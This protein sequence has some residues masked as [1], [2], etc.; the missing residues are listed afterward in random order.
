MSTFLFQEYNASIEYFWAPFIVDSTSDN[1]TNHTV[2][3]RL[4]KLDSIA[5]HGKQWEGVDIFVFES[6]IWWMYKPLINAT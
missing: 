5:K 3:K 1:A 4:V 2:L 6:Y